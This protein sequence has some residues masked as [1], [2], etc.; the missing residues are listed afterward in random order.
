MSLTGGAATSSAANPHVSALS[1]SIFCTASVVH[2]VILRAA[3]AA[4]RATV[5][6][7]EREVRD[8]ICFHIHGLKEDMLK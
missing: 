2:V 6:D 3:C 4:T 5:K 8:A 7:T 1:C